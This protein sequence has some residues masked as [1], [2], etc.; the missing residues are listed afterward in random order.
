MRE[1][2]KKHSMLCTEC[3]LFA[4]FHVQP[5]CSD[6]F[7]SCNNSTVYIKHC[8][9][10]RLVYGPKVCT[11]GCI[12]FILEEL[13]S[14]NDVAEL[15]SLQPSSMTTVTYRCQNMLL[16]INLLHFLSRHYYLCTN[17][18]FFCDNTIS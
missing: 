2:K 4:Y 15:R 18:G 9:P 17:K 16:K 7:E 12:K 11:L 3:F 5:M 10:L 8:C 14:G 1:K 13:K 6:P